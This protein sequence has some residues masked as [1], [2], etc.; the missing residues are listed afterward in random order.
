VSDDLVEVAF[1][2]NEY[3]A[4]MVQALL[5]ENEIPSLQQ[6]VGVDGATVGYAV[7][8]GGGSRRVMVHTHRAEEARVLLAQA[9]AEA[10]DLPEP[11][12][13]RHLARAAGQR[14]P[15]GYGLVGAYARILLWSFGAFAVA[16]GVFLLSRL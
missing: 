16:F 2:S 9:R 6:R 15:R 3:E 12:N 14:G 10:E 11:V 1:V 4:A 8:S 7:L 5:E 13:A